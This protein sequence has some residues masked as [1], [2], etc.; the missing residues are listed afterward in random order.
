M[1]LMARIQ[2]LNDLKDYE[3]IVEAIAELDED[4]MTPELVS[5]AAR[6]YLN[7]AEGKDRDLYI[8]ALQ[9]LESVNEPLAEDHKWNY[10]MGFA[11]YWLDRDGDAARYFRKAL[12]LM[13]DDRESQKLLD[14][15]SERLSLPRFQESFRERVHDT[16]LDFQEN[17]AEL[18]SMIQA[19]IAD[20]RP[21][22]EDGTE[23][24]DASDTVIQ[25][26]D[27]LLSRAFSN[28]SFELGFNGKKYVLTLTCE[29][30][31]AEVFKL[32]Y[33]KE[34]APASV[35]ERWDVEIGRQVDTSFALD[36]DDEQVTA[37]SVRCWAEWDEDNVQIA[38]YADAVKPFLENG[39]HDQAWWIISA[40]LDHTLGEICAMDLINEFSVL[41]APKDTDGIPLSSLPI[42][43]EKAG[44]DLS[45]DPTRI[46]D[47]YTVYENEPDTDEEAD[48]RLDVVKGYTNCPPL[49][50]GYYLGEDYLM[51]SF[52]NDGA[53]PGFFCWPMEAIEGTDKA[54]AVEDFRDKLESAILKHAGSNSV[55]FIG[56]AVGLF[57]GYLDFIAWDLDE[58]LEAAEAG[59][60]ELNMPAGVFHTF[61]REAETIGV[62]EEE[63]EA[64]HQHDE[65]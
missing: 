19:D 65:D 47:T 33:F 27:E 56:G 36:I 22:V 6:A 54:A 52:H 62:V 63:D 18:R 21:S 42:V 7:M 5:E 9:L 10:R 28:S 43:L 51:D 48:W 31:P 55:T 50:D 49:L 45:N 15:C 1:D 46:T 37:D 12:E 4:Q 17:E 8:L 13:P 38:L 41:D 61:R 57:A 16:W 53:V 30:G 14:D 58:V 2:I 3:G 44:F 25:R 34:H 29:D 32:V 64:D 11:N 35:L 24:E 40:L 59:F 20:I 26:C 23:N 60:A 39:L